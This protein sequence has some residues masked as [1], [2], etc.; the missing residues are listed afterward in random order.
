MPTS[1]FGVL[2]P[3]PHFGAQREADLVG[4]CESLGLVDEGTPPT[5]ASIHIPAFAGVEQ[6]QVFHLKTVRACAGK[7]LRAFIRST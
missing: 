6:R 3:V 1:Q 5:V 7:G 2:C 4:D